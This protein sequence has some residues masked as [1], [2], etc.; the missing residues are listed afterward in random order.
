MFIQRSLYILEKL[1]VA[2]SRDSY[3]LPFFHNE[4]RDIQTNA[5]LSLFLFRGGS[6]RSGSGHL[7]FGCLGG[8]DLLV[9][10]RLARLGGGARLARLGFSV[11][12]GRLHPDNQR[13]SACRKTMS[14]IEKVYNFLSASCEAI[15]NKRAMLP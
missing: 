8:L 9:G 7:C 12:G 4:Y 3:L 10:A 2:A 6:V 14:W 5:D 1:V 11:L 13:V 15:K